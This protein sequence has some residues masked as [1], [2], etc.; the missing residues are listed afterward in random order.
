MKIFNIIHQQIAQL[1]WHILACFGLVMVLPL[2]QAVV[3]FKDGDGF[4]PD[5][6][7]VVPA[8]LISVLLAGLI[9][10]YIIGIPD[11][12][13]HNR[14]AVQNVRFESTSGHDIRMSMAE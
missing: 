9:G 3:N 12:D 8:M 6:A 14:V 4:Y 2:E 10:I 13:Q 5:K 7:M 1:K 11:P